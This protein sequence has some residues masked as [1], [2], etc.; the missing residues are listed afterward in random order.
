MSLTLNTRTYN[1]DRIATDS[2]G[3]AGPAHTLTTI[4]TVAFG[5]VYPK[6]TSS[7]K[8]VARPSVKKVKSQTINATTGETASSIF[9]VGA[10]L[11]VG[12]TDAAIEAELA[13]LAAFFASDDAKRLFKGLD[14]NA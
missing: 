2:V 6:P 1:A 7:F 10:S 8:G 4:D 12:M 11:P 5:R 3:Y 9:T 13:D 14:I